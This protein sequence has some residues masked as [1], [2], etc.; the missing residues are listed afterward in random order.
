MLKIQRYFNLLKLIAMARDL[1]QK[2]GRDDL[3]PHGFIG[4]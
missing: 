2:M 4:S 3:K 1:L